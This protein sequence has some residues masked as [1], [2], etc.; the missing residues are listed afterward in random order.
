MAQPQHFDVIV[1]G[2]GPAGSTAA[3]LLAQAGVRVLV[4][5][6][7]HFPR[8]HIG[9]S[10]L[11]RGLA[12]LERL[13]VDLD[14]VP[15]LRKRGAIFIDE[16]DGRE[17]SFSFD[18]GLPGTAPY[19]HQVDRAS[20][21]HTLMRAA[22]ARGAE[23][24]EGHEVAEFEFDD[25]GVH[26]VAVH[27]GQRHELRAR[28]LV[29]ATG[30]NA[31]LARRART[32]EPYHQFGR[33]AAFRRY[34]K[35]APAIAEELQVR[36]DIY[37][38]IVDDGW[39][40]IIPLYDG[41]LSI[42]LVK[43]KGKLE[44]ALLEHEIAGSPLMQ[45]LIAGADDPSPIELIGNYSYKNT[46]PFGPGFVCIGDAACFLDPVFSSGV[47]LAMV[48]AERMVELLVP[49]LRDDQAR[50]PE[51]MQPL[52]DHLDRAYQSFGRFIHR[53]Y[54]SRLI[55]NILLA[56]Q[57]LDQNFRQGV[58]SVLAA[59]IWRDDNPFQNMLLDA[60]R[61]GFTA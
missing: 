44:P 40:W 37:I 32:V 1:I 42:G 15:F 33:A 24:R 27:E 56:P 11:P 3:N 25:D 60:R 43:S 41:E 14:T 61:P 28:Y 12:V 50:E 39:M 23:V 52:A 4:L 20:F 17:T 10:L 2:A 45:R 13:G 30:Q 35:L 55:D 47:T 53:F 59:D 19:A 36:G 31:L 22:I 9:E 6:R 58:I 7:E 21:D 57:H 48:G 51:L 46:R 18:E 49:A 29:D 38:R 16:R 54:N 34:S 8:F 26:V 5:E